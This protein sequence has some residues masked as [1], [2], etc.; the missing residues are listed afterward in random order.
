MTIGAGRAPRAL[1]LLSALVG[2][3]AAPV[4]ASTETLER[5]GRFMIAAPRSATPWRTLDLSHAALTTRFGHGQTDFLDIPLP[6]G[7]QVVTL[8][9]QTFDVMAPDARVIVDGF[10]G[11]RLV[12]PPDVQLLRG[13]IAGD[14]DSIAFLGS[15]PT[16]IHGYI[17]TSPHVQG[18]AQTWVISTGPMPNGVPGQLVI[19]SLEG[20][21]AEWLNAAGAG[22]TL[23]VPPGAPEVPAPSFSL[24]DFNCRLAEVAIE[25]DWEFTG[26]FGG[27]TQASGNYAAILVGATSEIYRR[28][29]NMGIQIKYLRLWDDSNDPWTGGDSGAQLDQFRAHW[30]SNMGSVQRD[31]AHFFSGRGLGGGVAWLGAICSPWA[32]AV[33]GNLGGSF[34]YPLQNNHGSNWDI[35]VVAHEWGHNFGAQHTH[36]LVPAP[37]L[38]G[39]GNCAGANQGTIMSYCHTCSGGM[40]NVLLSFHPQTQNQMDAYLASTGTCVNA[41]AGTVAVAESITTLSAQVIDID[42]L[43]NDIPANCDAVSIS[44]FGAITAMGGSVQRLTG[45]GPGGR[46]LL[47]YT[48]PGG[49]VSG[50]DTI[51]YSVQAIGRPPAATGVAVTLLELRQPVN[52]ASVV[53]GLEASYYQMVPNVSVL[54]DFN[55]LAPYLTGTVSTINIPSTGGN[56][57]PSQRAE[58]VGAVYEGYL[59]VPT[60]GLYTLYTDSDDGSR[61]LIGSDLVVSNDGLHGMLERSGSI[62]LAAGLHPLRVEFFENQ[63]GA[64]LIVRVQGP[65]V[66]KQVVPASMFRRDNACRPDLT[67]GAIAGQPGYGQPNGV[68]NTDDFFYYLQQFTAGNLAVADMTLTAIAGSPGYGVPNGSLTNDDFFYYLVIFSAGC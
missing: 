9:L 63:G 23:L 52:P 56:F 58:E 26:L 17:Q 50:S 59:S 18:G 33:S 51:L 30:N 12:A 61:A 54:P 24:I 68:V 41:P 31:A 32:Y 47:R 1:V 62:A 40:A 38:C 16:G 27:S 64:G 13:T 65:G 19:A 39:A 53:G 5:P 34:P 6:Q 15:S 29:L 10:N 43:A 14:P 37:D 36:D 55:A 66:N 60:S 4:V 67:T 42:V 48:A 8:A 7:E 44:Q 22:C 46:D 2:L 49:G 11:E 35:M 57:G 45:A 25:T 20:D 21:L 28:D 3:A